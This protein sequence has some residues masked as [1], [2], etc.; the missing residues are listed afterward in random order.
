MRKFHYHVVEYT[1]NMPQLVYRIPIM[2]DV[3]AIEESKKH[4][5]IISAFDETQKPLEES[6]HTGRRFRLYSQA[7][8]SSGLILEQRLTEKDGTEPV[9][10]KLP[11]VDHVD[12]WS[13]FN[14]IGYDHEQNK[15]RV[16]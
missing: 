5:R 2:P 1:N 14:S 8:W 12:I 4:L 16:H 11:I 10:S 6:Q 3:G 7:S 9:F 15:F 13:F